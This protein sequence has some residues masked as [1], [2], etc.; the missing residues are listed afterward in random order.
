MLDWCMSSRNRIEYQDEIDEIW[1]GC[2]VP[3]YSAKIYYTAAK[4]TN[5][6]ASRGDIFI[7]LNN[8]F[9]FLS[10]MFHVSWFVSLECLLSSYFVQFCPRRESLKEATP[11]NKSDN[12]IVLGGREIR[13]ARLRC[14]QERTR[15]YPYF[16]IRNELQHCFPNLCYFKDGLASAA[17]AIW[18]KPL[19]LRNHTPD[20]HST[21]KREKNWQIEIYWYISWFLEAKDLPEPLGHYA[22]PD[23]DLSHCLACGFESSNEQIMRH[24]QARW[25]NFIPSLGVNQTHPYIHRWLFRPDGNLRCWLRTLIVQ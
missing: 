7:Y 2:T 13:C 11:N 22:D 4:R 1:K 12:Q 9:F 25:G 21:R 20:F 10:H 24:M 6:P 8:W 18:W 17:T 5:P 14:R 19:L 3:V 23:P 15:Q 16:L